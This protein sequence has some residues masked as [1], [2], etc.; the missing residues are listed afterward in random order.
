[1]LYDITSSAK[2]ILDFLVKGGVLMYPIAL[3]SLISTAIG[4]ERLWHYHR[5]NCQIERIYNQVVAFVSDR[6]FDE[7]V[8]FCGQQG[9]AVVPGA[10]QCVLE[11]RHRPVEDIEKLVS[12]YGTRTIQDLSHSVRFLG[13]L[14]NIT[15]LIGLLGTVVGMV[16]TFM[17]VAELSGHVNPTL[18]AGGI[19]EALLTTAAGL[20]VAIPTVMIYHHCENRIDRFAF[21]IKNYTLELIETLS[22]YD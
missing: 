21:Q 15:P 8:A 1:M 18:L 7:A 5:A 12:V 10:L 3:I 17:K 11:N 22:D 9:R 14:G 4:I 2:Q 19:W 16:K 6:R 20:T 13:M